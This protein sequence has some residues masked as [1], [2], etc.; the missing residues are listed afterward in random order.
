[1]TITSKFDGTCKRCGGSIKAG[2]RVDWSRGYGVT[3]LS[4]VDC[5]A[6]MTARKAAQAARYE[7]APVVDLTPIVAFLKRATAGSKPLKYPRAH[8]LAPNGTDEVRLSLNGSGSPV[9]G[10]LQVRLNDEWI[11]RVEPNGK[12]V[13]RL[14]ND[15]ALVA[16]LLNIANDPATAAKQYGALRCVCSFCLTSLD[17]EGS[18]EVGYGPVCAKR[19]ELPHKPK[20]S[21][22]LSAVPVLPAV[23]AAGFDV[24]LAEI[25]GENDFGNDDEARLFQFEDEADEYAFNGQPIGA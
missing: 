22:K 13:G 10:S 20:G 15:A 1:M 19:Y 25:A 14:G 3:H 23:P 4:P 16:H 9:P 18:I 24:E 6:V 2:A 5:E 12:V 17:D 11:G 8:F 21:K 7:A